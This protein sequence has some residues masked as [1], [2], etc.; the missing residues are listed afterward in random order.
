L[1]G[2]LETDFGSGFRCKSARHF[3]RT[4]AHQSFAERVW[5]DCPA[6]DGAIDPDTKGRRYATP[7]R[8]KHAV[9]WLLFSLDGI[10]AS[11]QQLRKTVENK[12]PR[13]CHGLCCRS[14]GLLHSRNDTPSRGWHEAAHRRVN[15]S[16]RDQALLLKR[17]DITF[18]RKAASDDALQRF[19]FFRCQFA[20]IR[21]SVNHCLSAYP[22]D[23]M[24]AI[25][26]PTGATSNAAIMSV[27]VTENDKLV[28]ET[29]GMLLSQNRRAG[30]SLQLSQPLVL[31]SSYRRWQLLTGRGAF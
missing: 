21:D 5:I 26:A 8:N 28:Q 22:S 23:W 24:K 1:L 7:S 9:Q 6:F 4:I 11:R 31:E 12:W 27:R 16:K 18:R 3:L 19:E 20:R 2:S 30:A 13:E 10:S 15:Q 14:H 25:L 17:V 29:R